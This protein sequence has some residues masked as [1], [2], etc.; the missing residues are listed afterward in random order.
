MLN[1]SRADAIPLAVRFA[2]THVGL[3]RPEAV[4]PAEFL[5]AIASEDAPL[6]ALEAVATFL[7]EA[8]PAEIADLVA[9]GAT[10]FGRLSRIASDALPSSHPNRI[11]LDE[12][13][14]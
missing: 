2:A 9:C 3:S 13:A 7:D 1:D 4:A 11:Y 6:E 5:R 14:A 12:L 10:T 8:D